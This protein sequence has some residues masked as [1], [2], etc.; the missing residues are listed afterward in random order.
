MTAKIFRADGFTPRNTSSRE[1]RRGAGRD[2]L[3]ACSP[4]AVGA[5]ELLDRFDEHRPGQRHQW[6]ALSR[7]PEAAARWRRGGTGSRRRRRACRPEAFENL[8]RVVQDGCGRIEREIHPSD[9]YRARHASPWPDYMDYSFRVIGENPAVEARVHEP[10]CSA[11]SEVGRMQAGFQISN[12][13]PGFPAV[14]TGAIS[15]LACLFRPAGPISGRTI[16][17]RAQE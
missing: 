10:C 6:P 3:A 14:G 15:A 8:L 5:H 12:S 17:G 9:L 4:G 16:F 1:W 13:F 11:L 2:F 7:I